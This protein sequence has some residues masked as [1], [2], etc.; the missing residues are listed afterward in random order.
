ML[1]R[2]ATH[3]AFELVQM[4]ATAVIGWA[5]HRMATR[6]H[7]NTQDIKAQQITIDDHLKECNHASQD[8][9]GT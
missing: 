9:P 4:G 8:V 1:T 7:R 3:L 2:L 6:M 5:Y